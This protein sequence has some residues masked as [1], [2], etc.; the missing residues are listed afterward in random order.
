MG[1]FSPKQPEIIQPSRRSFLRGAG[2]SLVAAPFVI[3]SASLMPV[4]S[5]APEYL[6]EFG[7]IPIDPLFIQLARTTHQLFIPTIY[8]QIYQSTPLAQLLTQ[9]AA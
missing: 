1:W 6:Y 5:I 4:R 8:L 2:A 7:P 3:K 9:R